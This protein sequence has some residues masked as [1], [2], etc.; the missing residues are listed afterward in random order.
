VVAGDRRH[1]VDE[2][3]RDEVRVGVEPHG[4]S[5]VRLLWLAR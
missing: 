4:V 1:L 2:R 5:V 3:L